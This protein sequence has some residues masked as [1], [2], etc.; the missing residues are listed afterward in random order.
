[1]KNVC[2]LR[3]RMLLLGV[4]RVSSHERG[5]GSGGE[6]ET[7]P[8][9]RGANNQ[10]SKYRDPAWLKRCPVNRG[11]CE[12]GP[13][14]K[15][16]A[17]T[18]TKSTPHLDQPRLAWIWPAAGFVF[19]SLRFQKRSCDLLL[20][21]AQLVTILTTRLPDFGAFLP[22]LLENSWRW[23]LSNDTVSSWW[24][25]IFEI[26]NTVSSILYLVGREGCCSVS[27]G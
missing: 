19:A 11:N 20:L 8:E 14:F 6:D 9:Y 25:G 5:G 4:F 24:E 1:M 13:I 26:D 21:F 7:A 10:F 23:D 16:C 27:P 3:E 18:K 17:T 12:A 2:E 15:P 22:S